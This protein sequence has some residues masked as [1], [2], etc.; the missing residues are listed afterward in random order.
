[1]AIMPAPPALVV[2]GTPIAMRRST[3]FSTFD[4][5]DDPPEAWKAQGGQAGDRE[6][7]GR[8]WSTRPSR[9]ATP[10]LDGA[11]GNP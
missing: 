5:E 11:G 3:S 4:N 2:A 9:W 8:P 1:M 10:D 6:P 7:D